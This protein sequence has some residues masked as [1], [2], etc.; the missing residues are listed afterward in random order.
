MT[1]S[2]TSDELAKFLTEDLGMKHLRFKRGYKNV[3][4]K[5]IEL[6][7]AGEVCELAIE[8]S[9][10]GAFKEN[11][12]SDDGAYIATKIICRMAQLQKE[13]KKIE[14][15][16]EKLG[17]PAEAAEV[18]YNITAEDFKAYGQKVLADFDAYCKADPR[19]HIVSPNYEGV[20]VA[21]DDE[22]VK[23]WLLLRTSLHDPV[24][25]INLESKEGGGVAVLKERIRPF[26]EAHPELK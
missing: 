8:T 2:V 15:L 11:Y 18:R 23:G 14:S 1:D 24:I 26:I 22:E 6:N 25:P 3:I 16:I 20:R 17:Q 10:H 9:G 13:G 21:F 4:D 5:G 12:F 19:F 7:A